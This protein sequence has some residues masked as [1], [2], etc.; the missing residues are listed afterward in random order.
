MIKV[1]VPGTSANLGPGFDCMGVALNIYNRFYFEEIKEG[2][3][4]EGTEKSFNDENN[5][6]YKAMRVAFD[7]IGYKYTGLR[8][9]SNNDVP[10]SRG[11][12]SSATCIVAGL[13]GA[14]EIAGRVLSDNDILELA[15][16]M[17]GHPDN[18]VPAFLGGC[19]TSIY[20]EGKVYYNKIAV[21]K[22]LKFYTLIPNFKLSTKKA[23]EILPRM[24][25]FSDAVYNVGRVSLM[26]S[27]LRDGK[28]ELLKVAGK[29]KLHQVYRKYLISGYDEIE[30]VSNEAGAYG[31][32]LSGAGPTILV[33]VPSKDSEVYN[34]LRAE[35]SKLKYFWD[36]KEHF[37][38]DRGTIVK[39][40]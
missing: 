15:T 5:L 24:V 16:E 1:L 18:V 29:D 2:I 23:R 8:I 33:A 10:V 28:F 21:P 35:V 40:K 26:T 9:V 31:V 27:A 39:I 34:K 17:E 20:E 37:I 3:V 22:G 25:D 32:F 14:N 12:G 19:V 38:C 7:K 30:K 13:V 6:I 4:V 36:I 11:L